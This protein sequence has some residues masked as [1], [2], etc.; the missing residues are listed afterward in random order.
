MQLD[1][2]SKNTQDLD[3][4]SNYL[5]ILLHSAQPFLPRMTRIVTPYA[6]RRDHNYP[7]YTIGFEG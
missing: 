4:L 2:S 3:K 1:K 7:N 5:S 6:L